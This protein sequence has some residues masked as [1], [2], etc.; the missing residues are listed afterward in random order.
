MTI[1]RLCRYY[2]LRFRRLQGKPSFLAGGVAVGIFVGLTPTLPVQTPLILLLA[3][4]TRTS[5]A[6]GVLSS[7]IVCNPFTMPMIYYASFVAG[8]HVYKTELSA[9]NI[10][11]TVTLIKSGENYG[12]IFST[13]AGQGSQLMISMLI[14]GILIAICP[15]V[16][17]YW[18]SKALF[19]RIHLIRKKQRQNK[20][21]TIISQL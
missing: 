8:N 12:E 9:E 17:S 14:G 15:A 18:P 19:T 4:L 16:M 21:K 10:L 11:D 13:L 5:F 6:A 1:K 20:Y 2:F 3:I 7:W